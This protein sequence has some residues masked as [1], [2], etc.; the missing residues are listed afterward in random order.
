M[1][2]R[3]FPIIFVLL[4]LPTCTDAELEGVPRVDRDGF[5]DATSG[6]VTSDVDPDAPPPDGTIAD[7]TPPPDTTP[8]DTTPADTTPPDTDG[9]CISNAWCSQVLGPLGPCQEPICDLQ[10][11]TCRVFTRSG[12]CAID[13]DCP[14]LSD[15]CLSNRCPIPGG[16]CV[17][18]N[19]CPVCRSDADCPTNDPCTI[20]QCAADGECVYQTNPA[21]A[22]C[23]S[24]AQCNDQSAC[25]IDRCVQGRCVHDPAPGCCSTDAECRDD[26]PCT[27][28]FCRPGS[29][30]CGYEEIPGCAP[31]TPELCNDF[32]PCTQDLCT[33]LG[34]THISDPDCRG[35]QGDGQCQDGDVC[36]RDR[37]V[38]GRCTH[39]TAVGPDG[40]ALCVCQDND[41]CDDGDPCTL[42]FCDAGQCFN[43]FDPSVENCGGCAGSTCDDFDPCTTDFCDGV[44][45]QHIATPGL[46]G[47]D[48]RCV[49]DDQCPLP[50]QCSKS[51]C[52]A[53]VG[54]CVTISV[55][56][57]CQGVAECDDGDRCTEDSCLSDGR[58]WHQAIPGCDDPCAGACDD[59]DPCTIDRCT[60]DGRCLFEPIPGCGEICPGGC[61]DGDPCTADRCMPES[62]RCL[63][64]PIAGC[65]TGCQTDLDCADESVCTENVCADD[66]RCITTGIPGCCQSQR[67]CFDGNPCTTDF[68]A[69]GVG[70]CVNLAESCDDNNPCTIDTCDA[71]G[72]CVSTPDLNN[73]ACQCVPQRLWVRSFVEGEA[74]DIEIDGSGFGVRWRVD[75]V[76]S[77]SPSQ[78]LRYGDEEG[79]D[80]DTGFRTFGRATGPSIDVPRAAREAR[81]DFQVWIDVEPDPDQDSFVARVLRGNQ[82]I[83]VWDRTSVPP[84]RYRTW[85]PVSVPLPP[86]VIGDDI[87]IRFVFDS[88]DDDDNDGQ[89]VFVDDVVVYTT[90]GP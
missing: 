18:I 9:G 34:C 36:T 51:F 63:H 28:D 58:C 80:Y 14:P 61:D 74:P 13:A 8:A 19:V 16:G 68:C 11:G 81:L 48:G 3:R 72:G 79:E 86:Q 32:N 42:D 54:S 73:P 5:A 27:R 49:S 31:C 71:N 1:P 55:P 35:C 52:D 69:P 33:E 67:D 83:V 88:L 12:C 90:C 47:C 20:G 85:V 2:M 82:N 78:S 75:G 29:G 45:C 10:S 65:Q 84:E 22:Q 46:P 87:R 37:C 4:S 23:Q 77:L 7:T 24:D 50:D 26:D 17:A 64:E 76:R 38:N 89:G 25:T 40:Q 56:E 6:D 21:C 57:C 30:I 60:A 43:V 44:N 59:N 70:L 39:E 62:G 15:P 53:V 41:Q 66:G